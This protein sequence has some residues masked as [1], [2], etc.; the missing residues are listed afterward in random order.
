MKGKWLTILLLMLTLGCAGAGTSAPN[1]A[2]RMSKEELKTRLGSSD[3][4]LLDVRSGRDWAGS[5]QKITGAIR[6]A[7]EKFDVWKNK[8][9]KSKTLVLY[10][11]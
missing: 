10:C 5:N 8:Y 11:A 6:A 3:L 2:P 4:V 7:P 9:P 1:E